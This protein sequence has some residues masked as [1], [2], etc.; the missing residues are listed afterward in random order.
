MKVWKCVALVASGGLLLQL[1]GCAAYLLEYVA[2]I[3]ISQGIS[4]FVQALLSA[5]SGA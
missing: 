1:G 3:A 5:G 4:A 2:Q